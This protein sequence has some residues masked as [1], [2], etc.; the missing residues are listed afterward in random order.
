MGNNLATQARLENEMVQ[1]AAEGDRHTFQDK[2]WVLQSSL[3]DYDETWY[4]WWFY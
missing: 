1:A 3:T 4:A 2:R